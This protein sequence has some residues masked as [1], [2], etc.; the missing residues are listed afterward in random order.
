MTMIRGKTTSDIEVTPKE[1]F[2]GGEALFVQQD[3]KTWVKKDG[4]P[5]RVETMS[6][7]ELLASLAKKNIQKPA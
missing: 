1:V 7:K 2:V 5:G 6:L 3:G 4:A